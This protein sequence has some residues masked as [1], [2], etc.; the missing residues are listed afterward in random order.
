MYP[1]IEG[2]IEQAT[3]DEVS[4]LFTQLRSRLGA[5]KGPKADHARRV[6]VAVDSVQ[7]LLGFLLQIRERLSLERENRKSRK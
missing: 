4:D 6:L 1:N 2:F 7:E 3:A 5:I